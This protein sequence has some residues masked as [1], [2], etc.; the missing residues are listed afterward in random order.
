MYG[1]LNVYVWRY[2]CDNHKNSFNLCALYNALQPYNFKVNVRRIKLNQCKICKFLSFSLTRSFARSIY[3][4]HFNL[5][6][7]FHDYFFFVNIFRMAQNSTSNTIVYFSFARHLNFHTMRYHHIKIS[8]QNYTRFQPVQSRER[9]WFH[10]L[11]CC[12]CV[13][14]RA[15]THSC[16]HNVT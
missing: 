14:A 15:R 1:I 2:A 10:C 9:K 7:N 12:E 6:L 16:S 8:T 13:C 4:I 3:F 5:Q 11:W